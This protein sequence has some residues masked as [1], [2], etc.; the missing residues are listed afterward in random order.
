M[1][2]LA[3]LALLP[4]GLA[5]PA[6]AQ[7]LTGYWAENP[8]D[9]LSDLS[10]GD[11]ER[12]LLGRF[13]F[14][15]EGKLELGKGQEGLNA[16]EFSCEFSQGKRQG[17]TIS[18]Q[19]SCSEAGDDPPTKGVASFKFDNQWTVWA[20]IPGWEKTVL[21]IRCGHL[22]RADVKADLIWSGDKKIKLDPQ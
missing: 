6:A 19:A 18:Y 17:A 5:G 7:S 4:L 22:D 12:I 21:W 15:N 3:C 20:T 14:D 8:D 2:R 11:Q 16:Y 1:S 9:C 13:R 10:G